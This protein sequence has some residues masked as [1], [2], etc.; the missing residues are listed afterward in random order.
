MSKEREEQE[1]LKAENE[2]ANAT[3]RQAKI[4]AGETLDE[5]DLELK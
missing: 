5:E 4:D 3:A 1:K 2:E